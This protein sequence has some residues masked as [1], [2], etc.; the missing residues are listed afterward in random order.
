MPLKC[1][2]IYLKPHLCKC[3]KFY[4]NKDFDYKCSECFNHLAKNGFMSNKEFSEYY[5]IQQLYQLHQ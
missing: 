1:G 3:G 2:K 4:S 5:P